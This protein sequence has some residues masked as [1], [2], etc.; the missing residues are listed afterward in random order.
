MAPS[1]RTRIAGMDLK[2]PVMLASGILG[3]TAAM[4]RA[5]A[6]SGVSAV[7]TKSVGLEPR[8]GYSNPTIVAVK[9]G[10][11]NALGLP[12]PGIEAFM[13]ELLELS[14]LR[15]LDVHLIVSIYGFSIDEIIQ[16]A[17]RVF[18]SPLTSAIELNVSCPHVGGVHELGSDP[19]AL[20]LVIEALKKVLKKPLIV[21]LSPN[22][23]DPIRVA[24]AAV[25]A[26][27][28]AL[29][30]TNTI[31]AMAIDIESG[32]PI[33]SNRIGGLSGPALKPIALRIVYEVSR[34]LKVPIIGC[35]GIETAQD[36]LEFLMAG[37]SAVQIGSAL[38][39]RGLGVFKH[40]LEGIEAYL[41]RKGFRGLD[42][43]IG[44]SQRY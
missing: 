31:R 44:L 38:A 29:T 30:L 3:T 6:L 17:S 4:L 43:V 7:V 34:S 32:R 20:K 21:K 16:V 42:D 27:A 8:E 14:D 15:S 37:A 28:D 2:N 39:T 24:K 40:I 12:N 13:K 23:G 11:I 33:L 26:G 22:V 5:V 25:D 19:R 10:F 1:L 41:S 35:G 36:A 9:G 18:D